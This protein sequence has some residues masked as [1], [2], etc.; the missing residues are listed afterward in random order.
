VSALNRT[1]LRAALHDPSA[2]PDPVTH[3][4]LP[5]RRVTTAARADA[6]RYIDVLTLAFSNDPAAR[7]MYP[8]PAEYLH[9]FPQFVHAFGGGAFGLR[10]AHVLHGRAAALWLPPGAHPDEELLSDLIHRSA[11]AERRDELYSVFDQMERFHPREPHWHL[12]LVG[13]DPAHQ[14]RGYGSALLRHALRG[15]DEQRLPAYLEATSP[16]NVELYERHGFAVVGVIQ[17]KDSP[18][19]FP[20]LRKPEPPPLPDLR[21]P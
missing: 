13:V 5:E 15:C 18:P 19:V 20:M 10:T 2:G 16:E 11:P 1:V 6:G 8:D 4:V 7:W 17:A 12:P 14:R 9:Y 21:S 3:R